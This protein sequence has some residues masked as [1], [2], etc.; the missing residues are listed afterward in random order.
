[1]SLLTIR[2]KTTRAAL[3]QH[4]PQISDGKREFFVETPTPPSAGD[5]VELLLHFTDAPHVFSFRGMVTKVRRQGVVG[6]LPVG[7]TVEIIASQYGRL[8]RA[9]RFAR[10]EPVPWFERS[11]QRTNLELPIALEGETGRM[12]GKT[13]D[14]SRGGVSFV[15][16]EGRAPTVGDTVHVSLSTPD[17]KRT[18]EVDGK[19]VW[20]EP[21]EDTVCA[22]IEFVRG[23]RLWEY[24][25]KRF[26]KRVAPELI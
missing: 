11:H 1:M 9:M 7:A 6:R 23:E 14:V 12:L 4:G 17:F 20:L 22:G 8:A 25:L 18:L 21:S 26:L 19:I 15:P 10:G 3:A 24:R 2:L 13:R 5:E 16:E